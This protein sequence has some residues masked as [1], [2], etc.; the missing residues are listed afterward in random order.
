MVGAAKRANSR[1]EIFDEARL[2]GVVFTGLLRGA[3]APSQALAESEFR[4]IR[5]TKFLG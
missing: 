5:S 4:A 2:A 1:F 3:F